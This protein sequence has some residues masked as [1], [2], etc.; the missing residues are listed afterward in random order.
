M[1]DGCVTSWSTHWWLSVKLWSLLCVN[2]EDTTVLIWATDIYHGLK[3]PSLMTIYSIL[4]RPIRPQLCT[5]FWE[6]PYCEFLKSHWQ[7]YTDKQGFS[8]AFSWKKSLKVDKISLKSA[9]IA[10]IKISDNKKQGK[11]EGF[12][13]CDRASNLKLDS[14]R[15]FSARVTVKFDGWPRKT[16]GHFFYTTSSF[17][18]HFKSIGEFKLDLQSRNVQSGSNSTIFRAVQPW[19]LTDDLEKQ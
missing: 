10:C 4:L 13:S 7:Y 8:K 17:V 2:N 1:M 11:S 18:H 19:N 3:I 12:D 16:I 9:V 15:N 6:T 14:K 5:L